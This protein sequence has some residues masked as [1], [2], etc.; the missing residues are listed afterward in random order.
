MLKPNGVVEF[1]EVDPRPRV[2]CLVP[3]EVIE[4]KKVRILGC[5]VLELGLS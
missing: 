5:D 2:N 1:I 3:K 4:S